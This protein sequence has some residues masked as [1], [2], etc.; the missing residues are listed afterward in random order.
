M[1]YGKKQYNY[2][3][4]NEIKAFWV[5]TYEFYLII[6]PDRID[7]KIDSTFGISLRYDRGQ[8]N[9][10]DCKNEN[11]CVGTLLSDAV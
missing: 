1:N 7:D 8:S 4:K 5:E 11:F 9:L 3:Q 10:C 6:L 2:K